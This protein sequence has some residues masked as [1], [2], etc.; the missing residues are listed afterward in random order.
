MGLILHLIAGALAATRPEAAAI[1]QGAAEA[2][3]VKRR[4]SPWQA[5]R[6]SRKPSAIRARGNCEHAVPR[7]TGTKPS[8]T[9]SPRPPK[10]STNSNPGLSHEQVAPV[11]TCQE[12]PF[13]STPSS[14]HGSSAPIGLSLAALDRR[15]RQIKSRLLIDC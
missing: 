2:N 6:P 11:A 7:W 15:L 12:R 1:I 14:C 13:G 5:A 3:V 4:C 8:P 10:P 9:P